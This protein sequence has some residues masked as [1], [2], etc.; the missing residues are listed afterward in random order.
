MGQ[1]TSHIPTEDTAIALRLLA[2]TRQ[3]LDDG[4]RW[5]GNKLASG[6]LGFSCD[7]L[8]QRAYYFSLVGAAVR[9]RWE[10]REELAEAMSAAPGTPYSDELGGGT[11]NRP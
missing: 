7:P 9:A 3:L 6:R 11:W 8:S 10:L 4:R 2:R 5:R 1:L